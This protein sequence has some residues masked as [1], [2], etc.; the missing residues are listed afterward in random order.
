MGSIISLFKPECGSEFYTMTPQTASSCGR[1]SGGVYAAIVFLIGV[2]I[3]III[4]T[5]VKKAEDSK[6]EKERTN[7]PIITLFIC[8]GISLV[9]AFVIFFLP[10]LYYTSQQSSRNVE[11]ENLK[12]RGMSEGEAI[13]LIS[14]SSDAT[15]MA[16]AYSKAGYGSN[17]G[18]S[19]LSGFLGGLAGS[20]IA[21]KK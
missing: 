8:L 7:R 11:I 16:Q 21:G 20:F 15:K 14:R 5:M 6:P 13:N 17:V 9:A 2:V 12:N 4:Y 1:L 19:A 3:S 10:S 18:T